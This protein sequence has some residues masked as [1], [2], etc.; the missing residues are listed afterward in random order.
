MSLKKLKSEIKALLGNGE[1]MK[2]ILTLDHCLLS[3]SIENQNV[4]IN[5]RSRCTILNKKIFSGVLSISEQNTFTNQLT[6]DLLGFLEE[7]SDSDVQF[8][9]QEESTESYKAVKAMGLKQLPKSALVDCNR[10]DA[11]EIY[12]KAFRS[13]RKLPYQFYFIIGCPTQ[14]PHSFAERII[15]ELIDEFFNKEES[16]IHY[17]PAPFYLDEPQQKVITRVSVEP[18]PFGRYNDLEENQALFRKYFGQRLQKI[19]PGKYP[20]L[21]SIVSTPLKRL[22]FRIFTFIFKIDVDDLNWTPELS[23]YLDWIISTFKSNPSLQ[24]SFKF[25]FVVTMKDAHKIKR[26]EFEDGI[27]SL[28]N[29][30]NII[31]HNPCVR[32][33]KLEPLSVDDLKAWF[34]KRTDGYYLE[35]IDAWVDEFAKKHR[36]DMAIVEQQLLEIFKLSH[37]TP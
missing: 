16:A 11:I 5:L 9:N 24:P 21:E 2:A 37:K 19:K 12:R 30:H 29:A 18:L 34:S 33:D 35:E 15:Y 32:I 13:N 36:L 17:E 3:T 1:L 28:F 7:L 27:Q 31:D 6:A 14:R 20:A 22:P 4:S 8:D 10:K 26:P 23:Q 25:I